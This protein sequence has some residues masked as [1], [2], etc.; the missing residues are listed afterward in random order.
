MQNAYKICDS[1]MPKNFSYADWLYENF[2]KN[3][4]IIVEKAVI[5]LFITASN[6]EIGEYLIHLISKKYKST[7]EFC[8]EYI[9]LQKNEVQKDEIDNMANRMSQIKLGKKAVQLD[10]LGYFTELLEVTCEEILSAGKYKTANYNRFTNYS[11]AVSKNEKDW[12]KYINRDKDA[13]L[14]TDE[15]GKTVLDYAF[16]FKN[17]KLL[18]YLISKTYIQ[19]D[20][21]TFSVVM[22]FKG[23]ALFPFGVTPYDANRIRTDLITLAIENKDIEMLEYFH[24]RETNRMLFSWRDSDYE[25]FCNEKMIAC[26]AAAGKEII[27]YFTNPFT[28]KDNKWEAEFVFPFMGRL[29]DVM[30]KNRSKHLKVILK[31]V[32]KQNKSIYEQLKILLS[33][34]F[35]AYYKRYT[36]IITDVPEENPASAKNI[37]FIATAQYFTINSEG[38]FWYQNSIPELSHMQLI[39]NIMQITEKTNNPELNKIIDEINEVY[40]VIGTMDKEKLISKNID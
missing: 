5:M 28:V 12:E 29:A 11:F 34:E 31:A 20:E 35:N 24:A 21:K 13:I 36:S 6:E 1:Q 32:A 37:S 4:M 8:K 7:R 27:E 33:T 40:T 38:L 17:Y 16:E 30:I 23:K 26:I 14:N 18:K 10:D 39:S 9:M 15:Y 2:T 25:K 22:K 3:G 19:F